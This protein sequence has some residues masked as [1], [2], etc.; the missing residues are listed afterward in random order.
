MSLH[1]LINTLHPCITTITTTTSPTMEQSA[2]TS[3]CQ[4]LALSLVDLYVGAATT[5][6]NIWSPCGATPHV[7]IL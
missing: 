3:S 1:T 7:Y 4:Y 6:I 5:T 2:S